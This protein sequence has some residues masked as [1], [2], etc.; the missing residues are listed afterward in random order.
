MK[1]KKLNLLILFSAFFVTGLGGSNL[2]A[3]TYTWKNVVIMGGGFISGIEASPA[4]SG[5]I[6]ARTD[7]GGAYLGN[8]SSSTWTPLTDM[9]PM[10]Q[11]NYLGIESIAPDPSN[12]NNVYAAAGMY[13]GSGNGVILSSTNQ[14]TSWTVNNIGIPMGGNATGRGMGEKLAVDPNPVSY[15]HL[16]AHEPGRTLVCR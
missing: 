5:L 3:Q 6:Y 8:N 1:F 14:G 7:V 11:G 12:A 16:R 13:L 15:T 2:F 9:F 4:Q 10:S